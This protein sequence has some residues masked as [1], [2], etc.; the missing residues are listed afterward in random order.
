M[1]LFYAWYYAKTFVL[2]IL[3]KTIKAHFLNENTEILINWR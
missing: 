3:F 2:F 1:F